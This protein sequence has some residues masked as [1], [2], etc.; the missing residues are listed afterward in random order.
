[1]NLF[2]GVGSILFECFFGNEAVVD[3]LDFQPDLL[4]VETAAALT[5]L[6]FFLEAYSV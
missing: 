3:V 2:A 4:A 1:M 6:D 5:F